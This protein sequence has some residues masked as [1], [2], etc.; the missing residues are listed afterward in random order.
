MPVLSRFYGIMIMMF[1]KDHNPPHVHAKYAG[2][3]G[4]FDIRTHVIKGGKLPP[5][6]VTLVQEW[7]RLHEKELMENWRRAQSDR[8]L[9][10]VAPLK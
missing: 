3:I 5:H 8:P 4:I 6:A 10:P 9:K 2:Q 1:F 7:L